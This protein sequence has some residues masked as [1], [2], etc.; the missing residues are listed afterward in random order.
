MAEHR[1]LKNLPAA[2]LD[3]HS[4]V[5]RYDR[6]MGKNSFLKN[7]SGINEPIATGTLYAQA[8]ATGYQLVDTTPKKVLTLFKT[9]QQDYFTANNGK[10]QGM[11]FKKEGQWY[12]EYYQNDKLISEKL[13]IKF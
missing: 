9:S 8:T 7:S 4:V 1:T 3:L 2:K 6:E 13:D 12:F 10:H 11:V 5:F